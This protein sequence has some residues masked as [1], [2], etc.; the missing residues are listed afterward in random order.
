MFLQI[1]KDFL[2]TEM[3]FPLGYHKGILTIIVKNRF[4]SS[5][6]NKKNNS[7]KKTFFNSKIQ[8]SL[9]IKILSINLSAF[10]KKHF[11]QF[12]QVIGGN[13]KSF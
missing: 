12:T 6:L 5:V 9:A 11:S 2:P 7:F 1:C 8:C 4:I 10:F 3:I 13:F